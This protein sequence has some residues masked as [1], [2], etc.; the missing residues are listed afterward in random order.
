MLKLE[1]F[2]QKKERNIYMNYLKNAIQN[3]L[4]FEDFDDYLGNEGL[5]DIIGDECMQNLNINN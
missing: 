3:I 2:Y 5:E 1:N 4:N